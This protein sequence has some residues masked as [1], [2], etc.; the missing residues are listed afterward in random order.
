MYAEILKALRTIDFSIE[1]SY[2]S[3]LKSINTN[4]HFAIT[5]GILEETFGGIGGELLY[6]PFGK[7]FALGAEIWRVFPRNPDSRLAL[8][9]FDDPRTT[10][11]VNFFYELPNKNTTF[12]ARLGQYLAED[13]GATFGVK[14]AFKNGTSIDAFLTGSN[15]TDRDIFGGTTNIY[16]GVRVNI[17]IGNIPLMPD[18]SAIRTRIE[19]IG[20]DTGQHLEKPV[21]LYELTEP[22]SYRQLTQNWTDLAH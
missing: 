4:T 20:R 5:G 21:D 11:H 10:G 15:E 13:L 22:M 3:W 19:Q 1:H 17:P 12:Y 18:G 14:T 2:L 6:R 9:T 16:S 8:D 7:T